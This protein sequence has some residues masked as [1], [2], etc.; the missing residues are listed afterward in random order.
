MISKK[1]IDITIDPVIIDAILEK[2]K[3]THGKNANSI[4]RIITKYI[5]PLVA[6]K[7]LEAEADK[8]RKHKITLTAKNGEF[9]TRIRRIKR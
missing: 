7:I 8:E 3:D 2:S 1:D 5:R 4:N 6:D 9:T